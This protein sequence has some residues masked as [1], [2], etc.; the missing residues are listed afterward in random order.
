MGAATFAVISYAASVG[1]FSQS[2][3]IRSRPFEDFNSVHVGGIGGNH[4]VKCEAIPIV[5]AE[6]PERKTSDGD[7]VPDI[8]SEQRV[9]IHSAYGFRRVRKADILLTLDKS[10][11]GDA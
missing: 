5:V 1:Q 9:A 4:A 6:D 2:G 7:R 11:I 8:S 10:L 3:P